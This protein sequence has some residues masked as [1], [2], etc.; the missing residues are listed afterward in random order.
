M[1]RVFIRRNAQ[2]RVECEFLDWTENRGRQANIE[3][4]IL[5]RLG[6]ASFDSNTTRILMTQIPVSKDW[7]DSDVRTIRDV[8]V[9]FE[10]PFEIADDVFSE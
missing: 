1:M 5:R 10:V 2:G 6:C 9:S 3:L 7:T 8:L 4:E